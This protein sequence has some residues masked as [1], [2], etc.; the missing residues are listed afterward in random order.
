MNIEIGTIIHGTLRLQDLLPVFTEFVLSEGHHDA[1][2]GEI[3][4]RVETATEEGDNAEYWDSETA[5]EDQNELFD[6]MD[7]LA[8]EG[9]YF[10][11]HPFNGS[12]FGFWRSSSIDF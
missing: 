12:D 1:D 3:Y 4:V 6:V 9:A 11:A 8:P 7:S 5:Q 10:G 2:I